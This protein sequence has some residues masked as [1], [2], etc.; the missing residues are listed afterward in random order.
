M[1]YENSPESRRQAAV[2]YNECVAIPQMIDQMNQNRKRQEFLIKI[3]HGHYFGYNR[4][5]DCGLRE[6]DYYL[7]QRDPRHSICPNFKVEEFLQANNDFESFKEY[8]AREN[9]SY[10]CS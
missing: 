2:A 8:D 7:F 10:R 5:C 1:G 4:Q 6:K 3:R 9:K